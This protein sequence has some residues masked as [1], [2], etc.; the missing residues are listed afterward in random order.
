M[1]RFA[2]EFEEGVKYA[3][4]L[5]GENDEMPGIKNIEDSERKLE[6]NE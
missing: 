6:E 5:M 1:C 2:K 3:E 4:K